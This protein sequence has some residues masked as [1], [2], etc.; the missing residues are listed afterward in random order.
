MKK[1]IIEWKEINVTRI[2]AILWAIALVAEGKIDFD[3]AA[4]CILYMADISIT[5]KKSK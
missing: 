1:P 2:I 3:I 5:L 4:V